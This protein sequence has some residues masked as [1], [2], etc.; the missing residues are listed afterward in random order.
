MNVNQSRIHVVDNI[1]WRSLNWYSRHRSSSEGCSHRQF[2]HASRPC[3]FFF[4]FVCIL[5]FF[6]PPPQSRRTR[7]SI[8]VY[9]RSVAES[10]L[11]ATVA[12]LNDPRHL[13]I[14]MKTLSHFR[15]YWHSCFVPLSYS[16]SWRKDCF[17]LSK[18]EHEH[19]SRSNDR[20]RWIE[21]SL[22]VLIHGVLD[23][24]SK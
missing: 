9:F 16:N 14:V 3:I 4:C 5:V 11:M 24:V 1:H 8:A 22:L 10:S 12:R 23:E 20:Q 2:S 17:V 21:T 19:S 6:R 13:M 15:R 7:D 18:S